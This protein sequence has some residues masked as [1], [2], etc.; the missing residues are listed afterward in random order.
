MACSA[1]ATSLT[2]DCGLPSLP[3]HVDL[4]QVE[5]RRAATARPFA[6]ATG[7]GS[8]A[9]S[10]FLSGLV[11]ATTYWLSCR[12]HNGSVSTEVSGWGNATAPFACCTGAGAQMTPSS[13]EQRVAGWEARWMYRVSEDGRAD[14]DLLQNHNAGDLVGEAGFLSDSID[15]VPFRR[16]DEPGFFTAPAFPQDD[17]CMSA[18]NVSCVGAEGFLKG[19]AC[20]RC[21]AREI[22]N[23]SSSAAALCSL[24]TSK[25]RWWGDVV[26]RTFCGSDGFA[27]FDFE[28]TPVTRYCVRYATSRG[29]AFARYLSCNAPEADRY[30]NDHEQPLC[31]C[32][33]YADRVIAKAPL[34]EI[35]AEC[36]GGAP[37]FD[38]FYPQCNCSATSQTALPPAPE[39]ALRYVGMQPVVQPYY[40]PST[41]PEGGWPPA[42]A[43]EAGLWFSLPI[44]G[45][46][47]GSLAEAVRAGS[48]RRG[49]EPS[50]TWERP[51]NELHRIVYGLDLLAHGWR[52]QSSYDEPTGD[53]INLTET[54]S[55]NAAAL[56]RAFAALDD[57]LSPQSCQHT[58][59]TGTSVRGGR[60][61]V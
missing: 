31:I 30:G 34:A 49:A 39:D 29:G 55:S 26:P 22:G 43:G 27:L 60:D 40:L 5:L 61:V 33:C 4:V 45:A 16:A 2:V 50:C 17:P 23:A 58:L 25:G 47:N 13:S 54:V 38:D 57:V 11:P 3:F 15:Y 12:A 1:T 24:D 14:P 10:L 48:T 28:R 46:C 37:Y 42:P 36:G 20:M 18:L 41:P 32:S 6:F 59:Y 52:A 51:H 21:A 35:E 7:T 44:G 19:D 8:T 56:S 9:H 53:R